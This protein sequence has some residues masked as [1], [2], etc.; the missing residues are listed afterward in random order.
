MREKGATQARDPFDC[1]KLESF[2]DLGQGPK[3]DQ[4]DC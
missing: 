3:T 1:G 4:Q 2:E